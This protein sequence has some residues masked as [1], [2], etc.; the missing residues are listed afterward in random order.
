MLLF[1]RK[2]PASSDDSHVEISVAT[3]LQ[4]L[5]GS[6]DELYRTL[7]SLM[8]LDP[9]KITIPI[10]NVLSEAREMEAKGNK[11]R[12]EVGYRIAGGI[13]LYKGDTEGVR[14]YFS[15]AAS[16]AENSHPEYNSIAK[17]AD[18]AVSVARK[19][20]ENSNSLKS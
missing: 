7:S 5:C 12:A 2:K 4:E 13:S 14:S 3:R 9:K 17:R 18:Q 11:I 10:E 20:Y 1:G 15:K 6:D 16:F 19:F 8:F